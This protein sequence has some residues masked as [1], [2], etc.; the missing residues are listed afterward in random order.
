MFATEEAPTNH[1]VE[2]APVS[3][4]SGIHYCEE[5]GFPMIATPALR[6]SK[7]GSVIQLRCFVRRQ[8]SGEFIAECIDLD[9]SAQAET[10]EGA[11]IGL[12]DAMKGYLLVILDDLGTDEAPKILRPSPLTHRMRYFI[13]YFKQ[14]LLEFIL[15]THGRTK[16]KFYVVPSSLIRSHC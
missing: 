12:Q 3:E 15:R 4:G 2:S 10:L 6:N 13:E 14:R 8:Q 9:I 11:I 5:C 16:K 1:A 7:D